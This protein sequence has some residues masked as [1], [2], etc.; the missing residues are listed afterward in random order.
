MQSEKLLLRRHFQCTES[1]VLKLFMVKLITFI[2]KNQVSLL[3]VIEIVFVSCSK[4]IDLLVDN[5]RLQGHHSVY[6]LHALLPDSEADTLLVQ[7]ASK[8]AVY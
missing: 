1:I 4:G 6:Y 3:S 7:L 2:A 5:V 8:K